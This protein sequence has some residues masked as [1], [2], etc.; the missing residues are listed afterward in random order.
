MPYTGNA[1]PTAVQILTSGI[2]E[3]LYDFQSPEQLEED[4]EDD[5]NALEVVYDDAVAAL[6]A[7]QALVNRLRVGGDPG[8]YA[9]GKSALPR[10]QRE[11]EVAVLHHP[12]RSASDPHGDKRRRAELSGAQNE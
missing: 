11:V 7:Q 12:E 4:L 6:A 10:L 1:N 2:R 8:E 9:K 5:V 3:A